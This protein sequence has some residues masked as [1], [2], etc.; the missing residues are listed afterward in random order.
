MT[1][2]YDLPE[3]DNGLYEGCDFG[4]S[5]GSAYLTVHVAEHGNLTM[6]FSKV[7]FYRFTALTNCT[8]EMT[9]AYFRLVEIDHKKE[10]RAFVDQASGRNVPYSILRHYRIFL[11]E[12]GCYDIFCE[13][14]HLPDIDDSESLGLA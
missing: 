9:Q 4:Q 3:F 5:N 12:T 1:A 10:L 11:D 8:A 14:V 13:S 6:Q 2:I 7:R